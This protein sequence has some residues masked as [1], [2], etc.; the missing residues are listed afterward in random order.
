[1][2]TI[3]QSI[4]D[5]SIWGVAAHG[6]V[7]HI[8]ELPV[9]TY[10]TEPLILDVENTQ[11][12]KNA[13]IGF[14]QD[15]KEVYFFT[16]D[17]HK[18]EIKSIL[19]TIPLV[20]HNIKY[21]IQMLRKWGYDVSPDQILWDTQVMEYVFDSTRVGKYGLK[22]LVKERFGAAYPD[23]KSLTGTG[24]KFKDIDTLDSSILANYNGCDTLFTYKL[25]KLQQ[26]QATAEHIRYWEEIELPTL[27]VLLEMEE[28]GVQIDANFI[29][30]L[31]TRFTDGI[32]RVAASIRSVAET[33]INLNSHKQIK[34]F[35]LEKAGLRLQTTAAEELHKHETIPLVKSILRYRELT[36]LKSTYTKPLIDKNPVQRDFVKLD[37]EVNKLFYAHN[38]GAYRLHARFNQCVTHT[39]RLSSSDPNL[40]N[41]PT[42]TE[43]GNEIRKG[44]IAKAWHT[45]V[46]G[47]FSQ[48]EPRLMA[49]FS[50]DPNLIDIFVK[51]TDLY[52]SV[53]S[54][55]GCD[56][57]VA[58]TLWL[59]LAYNAGPYKIA[60]TAGITLNQAQTFLE[61][62]RLNFKEFFYW[63]NKAIARTEIEGGIKTMFGRFI[64]IAKEFAHLGPNWEIQGTAS[65]IMKLAIQATRSYF[66]VITVHDEL[67]FELP[68]GFNSN[69]IK[70]AMEN[71]VQLS[72]PLKVDIGMGQTWAAAKCH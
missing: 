56:R 8:N 31:D 50:Q 13:G 29:R 53:A 4:P 5:V 12:G 43:E 44:F 69:V 71:V 20:G 15:G 35:L 63:K 72:I 27:R 36:K 3:L 21:D 49:H 19:S 23:F 9:E 38:L 52:D 11:D 70:E 55:V 17:V 59:A 25:W 37:P 65:D 45:L 10:I 28:R 47:D 54:Y 67:I 1:M 48:I 32:S 58:K 30:D 57:K 6:A 66:P 26:E 18:A 22:S 64:P 16:N 2:S 39:G 68:D 61:K 33:E 34:Q 7:L 51:G 24:K 41:I 42:R 46:D 62:M 40:Q 60:Q 14:T